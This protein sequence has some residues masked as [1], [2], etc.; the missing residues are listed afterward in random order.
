MIS[1]CSSRC[2]AR[3]S[4][5]IEELVGHDDVRETSNLIDAHGE[6]QRLQSEAATL[7]DLYLRAGGAS[8]EQLREQIQ[9]QE[10]LVASCARHAKDYRRLAD[11]LGLDAALTRDALAANQQRARELQTEKQALQE[12]QKQEAAMRR[13]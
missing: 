11:L 4:R 12:R 7:R 1:R 13:S 6:I 8:I 3:A 9:L 2:R 10:K 5:A